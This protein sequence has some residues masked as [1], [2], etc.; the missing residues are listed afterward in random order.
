MDGIAVLHLL[1]LE[2]LE[3]VQ[4]DHQYLRE[5]LDMELLQGQGHRVALPAVPGVLLIELLR[6]REDLEAIVEG[7]ISAD[8]LVLVL[9]L[10]CDWLA[11]V[12]LKFDLLV[13]L[14]EEVRE[15]TIEGL[16]EVATVA[17]LVAELAHVAGSFEVVYVHLNAYLLGEGL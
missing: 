16:G 15:R 2:G 5:A 1:V 10:D 13:A 3:P 4:V 7:G 14:G 8:V 17:L 9:V 12:D 11:Q 6:L